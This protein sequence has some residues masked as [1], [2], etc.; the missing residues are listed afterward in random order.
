MDDVIPK[1]CGC[2][3]VRA[4]AADTL[5]MRVVASC[6]STQHAT[7]RIDC[8]CALT[9]TKTS[10][11]SEDALKSLQKMLFTHTHT[12]THTHT[13]W[14]VPS[15]L[16]LNTSAHRHYSYLTVQ[17]CTKVTLTLNNSCSDIKVE[18]ILACDRFSPLLYDNRVLMQF[19][20]IIYRITTAQQLISDSVFM[21]LHPLSCTQTTNCEHLLP[22]KLFI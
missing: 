1:I 9:K 14:Q 7:T 2:F 3:D 5:H 20:S 11:S 10:L 16:N 21:W 13:P 4:E 17:S 22:I 15:R 18:L 12:H 8:D 6:A 19:R